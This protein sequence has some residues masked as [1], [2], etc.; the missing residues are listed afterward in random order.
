MEGADGAGK[1]TQAALLG[2]RLRA[3]GVE[4]VLTREPGGSPG[5][6][7][8]RKLLLDGPA[9]RWDSLSEA[10]LVYAARRDHVIRK[11]LPA[12]KKGQWV[13]CDRFADSSHA[14][15]GKAGGVPADFLDTLDTAVL[16]GL[17]PD[18]TL[19]LD[20]PVGE[21]L[22]RIQERRGGSRFEA[23]G[24]AYQERVRAAFLALARREPQRCR[25]I[26]AG[27]A[28]DE[29]ARAIWREVRPLLAA[30]DGMENRQ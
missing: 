30:T 27:P 24:A 11:I 25:L 8:V 5:A 2:E 28:P 1:S 15:Q 23:K 20:L 7:A 3:S 14:Y 21:S 26:D 6:E 16:A 19:I 10:L 4:I 17:K 22:A 12:L 9:A 13:L 18:L 29:V